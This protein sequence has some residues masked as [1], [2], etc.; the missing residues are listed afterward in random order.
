MLTKTT[1]CKFTH[2]TS[3]KATPLSSNASSRLSSEITRGR[4]DKPHSGFF[5]KK[6]QIKNCILL[7]S[8][9]GRSRCSKNI[10][11]TWYHFRV[12]SWMAS[13]GTRITTNIEKGEGIEMLVD[14]FCY[15]TYEKHHSKRVRKAFTKRHP[16]DVISHIFCTVVENV[17]VLEPS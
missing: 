3:T 7:T 13:D 17:D 16:L 2:L 9:S 10:D 8:F 5:L 11:C 6:N 4:I 12:I 15:I 1:I 14:F